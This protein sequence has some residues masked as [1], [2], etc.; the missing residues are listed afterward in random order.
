[1]TNWWSITVT[2]AM[3]NPNAGFTQAVN[4]S[5]TWF[6]GYLYMNFNF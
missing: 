2:A 1:M 4:G 6:S 5:A 3:A